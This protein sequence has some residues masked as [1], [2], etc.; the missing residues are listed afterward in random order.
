MMAVL[1]NGSVRGLELHG[2]MQGPSCW[3]PQLCLARS[4]LSVGA[5]SVCL[6]PGVSRRP[7]YS[8][9]SI[10]TPSHSPRHP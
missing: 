7:V 6:P 3:T 2:Q 9:P 1:M 10:L 8:P 4:D 5:C